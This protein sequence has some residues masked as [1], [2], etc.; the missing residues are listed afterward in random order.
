M[1][2]GII[3]TGN[4]G[5]ILADALLQSNSVQASCLKVYNRTQTKALNLQ[6]QHPQ[7]EISTS[8]RQI[9]QDCQLI[10]VCVKP[11]DM[12]PLFVEMEKVISKDKCV[13]SITSPI[14]TKQMDTVLSCSTARFIPSITNKVLSGVSLITFG[15]SCKE[16]WRQIIR[17]LAKNISEGIEI[18]NNITRVSSD[19]VS[20]GPAFFSYLAQCFIDGATATTG[21]DKQT[22][23]ILT[24]KM[25]IG[26]GDL[27]K[28][29]QYS[30]PT[31]QEKVCV[32]GGITG[33]GIKILESEV[34]DMF[35]QLF[36]T[37]HHKFAEEISKI[38]KQ[39]HEQ[40]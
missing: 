6:Q 10:F 21:I 3:G 29:G 23:T 31:L 5:S 4:M 11:G 39:F 30:L 14:S 25:L 12:Y 24:E 37:T 8:I 32:K 34:G 40:Y 33:E 15:A 36:Q 26:F 2:V 35:Q 17:T 28:S 7:I 18:E 38:E 9:T 22:A 13:V 1:I 27:L 19:I 20:C 16:E